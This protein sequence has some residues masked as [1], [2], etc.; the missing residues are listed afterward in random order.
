MTSHIFI[1]ISTCYTFIFRLFNSVLL[2]VL[3]QKASKK[4]KTVP[5][6]LEKRT[7]SWLKPSKLAPSSLK[8]DGFLTPTSLVFRLIGQG[9]SL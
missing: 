5:A 7:F 4:F 2:F 3:K 6:S 9:Q 8:Q 1:N